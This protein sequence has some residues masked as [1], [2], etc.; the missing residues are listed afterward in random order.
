M[1]ADERIAELAREPGRLQTPAFVIDERQL[2]AN[3]ATAATAIHGARTRLLFAM[4]SFSERAALAHIA[5]RVDGLHAS[6]LFEAQ[7]ARAVLRPD[8]LVHLTSPAV[9]AEELGRLA[10]L[11]N[12]ISF[13][14]LSQW[15]LHRARAGGR[16]SFGL[17]VN[18]QLSLVAD[19]RYDPCRGSSK[20]GVPLERL[21][22]VLT[23]S[24]RTLEGIEGLLVHSNCD[25]TDFGPLLQTVQRLEQHIGP[26]LERAAWINLGGGYLFDEAHDFEPLRR[27]IDHLQSR[28]AADILFEPGAAISRSAGYIVTEIVDLFESDGTPV[29]VLDTSVNHMPEVFEYQYIPEVLAATAAGR[30]RYL[31]AGATCLAGDL[32]G[33]FGFD[34]ALRIGSRIVIAEAGAYTLVRAS[35]FNG[36]NLPNFYRLTAAGELVLDRAFTYADYLSRCG[37]N[38]C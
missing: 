11:C 5:G 37:A 13:N 36:V 28:Y 9:K 31:L 17:R 34:A 3:I 16:C 22:Q 1:S 4:K 35:M 27:L 26:L 24:P 25:S 30:H 12:Y 8:G 7:L 18:P 38:P 21:A 20:L 32:F 10:E 6:S 14:S 29:A 2:D 33:E 23:S 15:T 19:E